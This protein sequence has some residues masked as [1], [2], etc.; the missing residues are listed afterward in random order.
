[1]LA[2]HRCRKV[3]VE[4]WIDTGDT[5]EGVNE[6]FFCVYVLFSPNASVYPKVNFIHEVTF[7]LTTVVEKFILA[8]N[9]AYFRSGHVCGCVCISVCSVC[10]LV[11]QQQYGDYQMEDIFRS[12]QFANLLLPLKSLQNRS[13]AYRL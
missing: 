4:R 13:S 2:A 10:L 8:F 6:A 9:E 1:M 3:S 11:S 7:L 12:D 5:R